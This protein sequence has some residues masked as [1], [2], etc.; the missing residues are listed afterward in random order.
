MDADTEQQWTDAGI[1]LA[2]R[3]R[4]WANNIPASACVFGGL[5]LV[6]HTT[7]MLVAETGVA[8]DQVRCGILSASQTSHRLHGCHANS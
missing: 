2:Q 6:A 1:M 8:I 7:G 4:R 3:R 5:L